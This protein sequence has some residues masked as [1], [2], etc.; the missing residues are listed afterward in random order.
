[1]IELEN[2]YK[3]YRMGDSEVH[4]LDGVSLKIEAG[5]WVAIVGPSGSGKSTLMN[6]IGCLDQPTS[7]S[8]KLDGVEVA[9]MSDREL[10]RVR[11]R[12]IGFVFQT[13]NLLPRTTALA[14]VELPLVYAGARDRRQRA[15]AALERVGLGDRLHHRPNELSGGQQQRV[16]IARALVTNPAIILADEPTGNL[17]SKSGAE[18]MELFHRLHTE[19]GLT[20]VMVTHDPDIAAQCE[21]VV[22]IRDGKIIGDERN[23]D[24]RRVPGIAEHL[25]T[26]AILVPEPVAT[27]A[28]L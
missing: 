14:N 20:I 11:N 10:A 23:G 2:V 15:I 5:E 28:T 8:Y 22:H 9:R 19:Q 21:R 17:D 25:A 4:A 24:R 16:A 1:M 27:G 12:K 13:F 3:I 26:P 7:G 18:I 6:V